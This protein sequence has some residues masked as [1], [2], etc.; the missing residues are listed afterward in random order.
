MYAKPYENRLEREAKLFSYNLA[1]YD[2]IMAACLA[3]ICSRAFGI[4]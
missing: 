3:R 4:M 1:S 2:Y